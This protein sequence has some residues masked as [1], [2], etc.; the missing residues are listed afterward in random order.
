MAKITGRATLD[1]RADFTLDE[2]EMRA[3]DALVGYGA[4]AFLK[5]FYA[6]LGRAYMEPHEKGLRRL[7]DSVSQEIKPILGRA[8]AAREAFEG[9]KS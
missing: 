9:K 6:N 8:K 7:F 2:E 5:V 1:M 4:D 3:L